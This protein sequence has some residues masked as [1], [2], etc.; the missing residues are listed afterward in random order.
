MIVLV[1]C[2]VTTA[3]AF[4]SARTSTVIYAYV[5]VVVVVV[6]DWYEI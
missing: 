4:T 3:D 6:V 5:V 1:F 2:V